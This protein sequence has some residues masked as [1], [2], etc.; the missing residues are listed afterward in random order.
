MEVTRVKLIYFSPTGTTRKV[1]ESIAQG[2]GVA[3]VGHIDLTRPEGAQKAVPPF[4]DELVIIGAPVY[5]GRL[6]VDAVARF[7]KLKA[8]HT[9]AVIVV[10]YG[11]REFEDS[12]LELKNLAVELGFQPV[13]GGAFIGEHSLA[14][15]DRPI[16]NGRPDSLDVQKAAAFGAKIKAKIAALPSPAS[17]MSLE[18]PGRFPYEGGAKALGASPITDEGTCILC[19]TCAEVCPTAAIAVDAQVATQVEL[20][21]R[22]CACVKN[23]PTGARGWEDERV[24]KIATWL[25]EKCSARKEPQFFGI[26]A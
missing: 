10:V 26:E 5:G 24:E 18:I 3:D 19:G 15:P 9:L 16:A 12:L 23:C 22:C 2:I 25:N 6:P 17:P 20:C 7:Q 4:S 14:T 13:A 1:L 8:S 11:N 21:I